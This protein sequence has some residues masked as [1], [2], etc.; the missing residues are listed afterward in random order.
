VK[1]LKI[2]ATIE[3]AD[4]KS[5]QK[6]HRLTL[7]EAAREVRYSFLAVTAQKVGAE[8][9]AAGHTA[10]DH[11]ETV[12]MHLIR[13][14]GTR[15]LRGLL[16]DTRLKTNGGELR[17]IRPLLEISREETVNYCAEH[18]LKPRTDSSNLSSEPFRN[19]IRRKLFPELKKYN[20]QIA[21]ALL[22]TARTAAIDTDFIDREARRISADIIK[23][24]DDIVIIDKKSFLAVHPALQRQILRLS[25]EA[26]LGT[27][28][29][30]ESMHIESI[31]EALRKPAGKTISLPF[32]LNFHI[33]YDKYVLAKDTASLCPLPA[34]EDEYSLNI[35]GRTSLPGWE[36]KASLVSP[37][38]REN[39]GGFTACFDAAEAGRKLSVRKCL[40]DDRFQPLGMAAEKKLNRFMIDARIPRAWRSNIPIVCSGKGILWVAGWRIDERYRVRPDT[41][42]V[43]KLEFKRS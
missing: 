18:N 36:I 3:S 43:L 26:M 1:R 10:N 38:A 8:K 31:M 30:I 17:V 6:K 40:P 12:L 35:P 32:G 13:G 24:K 22:R 25:L 37:A 39:D 15:G 11:I 14:S 29:D 20:P 16:P 5:F 41:R 42:K 27:L 7:E 28:K 23:L 33:D 19:K 4:V 2:P 21:E 34:L 9:A